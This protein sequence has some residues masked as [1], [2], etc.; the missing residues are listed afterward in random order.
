MRVCSNKGCTTKLLL[1]GICI[2]Y[3]GFIKIFRF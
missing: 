2:K 3:K 1:H